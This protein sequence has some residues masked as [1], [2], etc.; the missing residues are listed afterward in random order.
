VFDVTTPIPL[1]LASTGG[2]PNDAIFSDLGS[3]TAFGSVVLP[4]EPT[5][6]ALVTIEFNAAGVAAINNSLGGLFAVGGAVTVG[7]E[8][9]WYAFLQS[10]RAPSQLEVEL[11]PVPEPASLLMLGVGLVG[12]GLRKR[13]T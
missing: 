5:R 8:F 13:R 10:F 11:A 3:G 12:L 4:N 2:L 1:L 7:G 9:G 6:P